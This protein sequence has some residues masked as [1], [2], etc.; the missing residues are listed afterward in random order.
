MYI[1][2]FMYVCMYV[3]VDTPSQPYGLG[4]YPHKSSPQQVVSVAYTPPNCGLYITYI[5]KQQNFKVTTGL[6]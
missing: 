4:L 2:T 3:Y 1:K 6:I 5:L